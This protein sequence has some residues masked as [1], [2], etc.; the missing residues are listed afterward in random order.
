V[1]SPVSL[2]GH[3]TFSSPGEICQFLLRTDWRGLGTGLG[4]YVYAEDR[5]QPR[6]TRLGL[7]VG[8]G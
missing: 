7:M 2:E 6:S 3:P 4:F 8:V 5:T 1:P